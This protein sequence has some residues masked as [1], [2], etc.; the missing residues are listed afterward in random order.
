MINKK[1]F[2]EHI[3]DQL[4]A[5]RI[6]LMAAAQATYEAATGEESKPEN[7]YDTRALEASYLAGAQAKRVSDIDEQLSIFKNLVPRNFDAHSTIS[8]SALV[9]LQYNGNKFY[10]FLL[11][12]GGGSTYKFE[13]LEIQIVTPSSPLGE[14][15]VAMKSGD[16]VLVDVGAVTKEY[17]IL[18][19]V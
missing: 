9:H 3:I 10:A 2:L 4:Q 12:K 1:K 6:D 16:S 5:L 19:V 18:D 11:P 8:V 17:E 14:A 7:Q 13:A 15:L